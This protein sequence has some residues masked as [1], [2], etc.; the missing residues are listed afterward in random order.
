MDK[1]HANFMSKIYVSSNHLGE[2]YQLSLNYQACRKQLFRGAPQIQ[3]NIFLDE[4]GEQGRHSPQGVR[5]RKELQ[6]ATSASSRSGFKQRRG[7]I[8]SW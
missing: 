3:V 1:R 5:G 7:V 4:T 2:K 8:R 6:T